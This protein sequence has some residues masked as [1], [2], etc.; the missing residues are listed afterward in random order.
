MIP[1]AVIIRYDTL[2]DPLVNSTVLSHEGSGAECVIFL[3]AFTSDQPR[4]CH[5]APLAVLDTP[6]PP[7]TPSKPSVSALKQTQMKRSRELKH[8]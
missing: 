6:A 7:G 8:D 2:Y 4:V 3:H 1:Q 5:A